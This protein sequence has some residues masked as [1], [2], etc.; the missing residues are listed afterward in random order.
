MNNR[1]AFDELL[2][3][4][5]SLAYKEGKTG[6]S[7]GDKANE[8]LHKLRTV[9]AS[10]AQQPESRWMSVEEAKATL[11]DGDFIYVVFENASVSEAVYLLE[12]GHYPHRVFS[13]YGNERIEHCTHVMRR[14]AVPL[15]PAP[16]VCSDGG[17]M[18]QS[19]AQQDDYASHNTSEHHKWL[20]QVDSENSGQVNELV[21]DISQAQQE[22]KAAEIIKEIICEVDRATSKYPTWPTDPLHAL[23][24]LGEEYGELNKAL[25]QLTYEPHKTSKE[26]VRMESIQTAAMALRL[27]MSLDQ[28]TYSPC[29]QHAQESI[30]AIPPA[31]EGGDK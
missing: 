1:E 24:V 11:K 16:E 8:V 7:Q 5:W 19:Q 29:D 6:E 10:Q 20:K 28:Y 18:V 30:R 3:D 13:H 21:C 2:Y 9:I 27:A 26:E 4:Y 23:A 22:S 15:P 12:Q 31:P 17:K 14:K 25:L